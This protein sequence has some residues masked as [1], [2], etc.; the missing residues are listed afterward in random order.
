MT[1]ESAAEFDRGLRQIL[2]RHCPNGVVRAEVAVRVVWG[3]PR[4]RLDQTERE[5]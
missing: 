1:L 2:A 4:E 3:V 5:G